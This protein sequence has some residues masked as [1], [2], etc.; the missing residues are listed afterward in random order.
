MR[1]TLREIAEMTGA[2]LEGD[3]DAPIEG[4]AGLVE[5]G[6]MDISFLENKKYAP[7][8]SASKAGA[9]FLPPWAEKKVP[10]GPKN[11]LYSDNA[12]WAY[13][14]VLQKIYDEMWRRGPALVS[15]KAEIHDEANLAQGVSVDPFAFVDRKA[16]I[17]ERT[18]LGSGCHIGRH[19]KI[20]KDCILHPRVVVADYCEV[21]DRCILHSGTVLGSDGYG[22][23]TDPKTGEHRK[24]QQVGN[25]VL[26]D[27]VETGANVT[28]DRA[29][30]GET[31]VGKGTKIDNLVQLG[32][33]VQIGPNGLIVAQVGVAGSTT[34]GRQVTLAGQAG[35]AGHLNIGDGSI[36]MA[37]SGIMSDLPPKSIV[38]GSPARHHREAMKLQALI[39]R[40][41]ELFDLAKQ[42]KSKFLGTEAVR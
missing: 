22:Y 5:A 1:L 3:P 11:R 38:F 28:I 15:E 36:V 8:V 30:T 14:Q 19:A 4:A 33:N 29:T 18:R 7:R 21:G 9:V 42:I 25:V 34:L 23:W 27:D 40:L 13:A 41:P 2:R 24:I 17:G 37:Q 12:R 26:E 6:E 10:G 20:G 35:L 16:R 39:A 32:H 31:R